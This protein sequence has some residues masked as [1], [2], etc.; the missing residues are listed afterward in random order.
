M[1]EWHTAQ[2]IKKSVEEQIEKEWKV[3]IN[4]NTKTTNV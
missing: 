3:K 2:K 1:P 4:L